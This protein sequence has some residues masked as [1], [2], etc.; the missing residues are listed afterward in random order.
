MSK[1]TTKSSQKKMCGDCGHYRAMIYKDGADAY[2]GRCMKPADR[3]Q[4]VRCAYKTACEDFTE[5][6]EHHGATAGEEAPGVVVV[7]EGD[8]SA[9]PGAEAAT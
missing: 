3:V 1:T 8:H 5:R 7:R 2:C 6:G 4:R 9:V